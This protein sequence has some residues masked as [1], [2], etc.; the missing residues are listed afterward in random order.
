MTRSELNDVFTGEQ[1]IGVHVGHARLQP[2]A[3]HMPD[4][5]R[6]GVVCRNAIAGCYPRRFG[7][8]LKVGAVEKRCAAL[9]VVR[10]CVGAVTESLRTFEDR[11]IFVARLSSRPPG[12]RVDD[13]N[14]GGALPDLSSPCVCNSDQR[15]P[16]VTGCTDGV[17]K[18]LP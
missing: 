1:D 5:H 14:Q 9:K 2:R 3:V 8:N 10:P 7:L 15:D 12:R 13:A 16:A 17:V 6:T 4:E 18:C 11:R